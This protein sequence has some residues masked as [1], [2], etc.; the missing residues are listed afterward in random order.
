VIARARLKYLGVSAQKTRLVVDQVRGR[1][2]GDALSILRFSP[3]R[4]AR[5]VEKA[6]RS[7][8]ANAQQKLSDTLAGAKASEIEAAR[9]SLDSAKASLISA[10][11]KYDALFEPPKPDVYLPLVASVEQAGTAVETARKNLADATIVAPFAGR[12][13]QRSGEVGSQVGAAVAVFIL[14]NPRLVR[15]DANVDQADVSNLR[16]GHTATVTF[17]ALTGRTY[18]ATVTAIGLT[19][20]IQQGVVTYVVSLAMDTSR[21]GPDVP[22]PAPGMTASLT[23]TISRTENALVV[24]ARAIRTVGRTRTVTVR[25]ADGSQESRQVVVGTTNGTLTQITSGIEEGEEVLVSAGSTTTTTTT[26]RPATQQLVPGGGALP[27]R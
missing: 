23:I 17:D 14:L 4:V 9:N 10:Q 15:I 13:S 26:Q 24:P 21:L 16:V 1:T 22:V 18:A 19:P 27:G 20:T 6:V 5:D 7:A 2:V 12:I 8:L 3:K 11:A 25:A